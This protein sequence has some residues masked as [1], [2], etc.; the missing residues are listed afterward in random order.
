MPDADTCFDGELRRGKP[1]PSTILSG[2]W[3]L[4]NTLVNYFSDI[5][6]QIWLL[7]RHPSADK[8]WR[9]FIA[10]WFPRRD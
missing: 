5:L 4:S 6:T 3:M 10:R 2:A 7:V 8:A 9:Q 1:V